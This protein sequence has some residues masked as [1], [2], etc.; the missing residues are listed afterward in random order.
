MN[1]S[2]NDSEQG[3]TIGRERERESFAQVASGRGDPGDNV[4][5]DPKALAQRITAQLEG[6]MAAP[7]LAGRIWIG[8]LLSVIAA[9]A[10]AYAYQLASGLKL[11]AM[12]EYISWGVY[13]A[14]FVFFIGISHAGTLISAILRVTNAEWRRSVTRVAEAITVFALMVGAP[15]VLIDMGRIDRILNI[16]FHGRLNSPL[17]WDVCSICTYLAGS[18]TFLYVA[19]IP[20]VAILARRVSP[21]TKPSLLQRFY[22]AASLRY[23]GTPEQKHLLERAMHAMSVIII[24]VAV[25]VHTVVSW[26]F[27]MTLRPGWH[28]TIF[29]PYF[30]VGAIYSGTAALI[31]AMVAFRKFYHL[32]NLITMRQFRA[33][34]A[35]LMALT[36]IYLYF[37]L[38][39]YLTSWYGGEAVDRRLIHALMGQNAYGITWWAIVTGCF[40]L[41]AI[42]L[43]IPIVFPNKLSLSRL[44]VASILINIGMWLK[45]YLIIV[46]TLMTPFIPAEAAGVTPH[47]TPTWVEWTITAGAFAVFLLLFTLFAKIFPIVSIW[48]T[49][50]GVEEL[51]AEKIGIEIDEPPPRSSTIRRNIP[52]LA[53]GLTIL[54]AAL[55][56]G[57]NHAPAAEAQTQAPQPQITITTSTEEGK[58]VIIATVTREGK[59]VEGS[60]VVLQVKRT[61]GNLTLGEDDTLADGTVAVPFP[62]DLPGGLEGKIQVLAE[63]KSPPELAATAM[64][65]LD[66]A[67]KVVPVEDAFPRALW[68]PHAPLPLLI[69]IGSL[70][71]IVWSVYL[72]VVIQLI[73]IRKA[74][75]N[76]ETPV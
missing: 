25:S 10:A 59:P 43:V 42:L 68:L 4:D 18:F 49:I 64:Q 45:R 40:L 30:V 51:G 44:V 41:P 70:L 17:L 11:T 14:N 26:I 16:I 38:A 55:L 75:V 23:R 36:V 46:P 9:G 48:E 12:R 7:G 76:E 37:T 69:T 24:P 58:K 21:G 1:F 27:G 39:E 8:S 63:I 2:R 71:S 52:G 29:G 65:A 54:F 22:R 28:S 50:E 19:M 56:L 15:M 67:S 62:T 35:L 20:D 32:E 72:F 61:F 47:Y 31:V 13:I 60:H 6:T 66:G 33:L 57:V 3:V 53:T 5:T 73:K 34:G 74:R